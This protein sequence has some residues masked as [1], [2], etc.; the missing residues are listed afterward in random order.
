M[1][2]AF[3]AVLANGDSISISRKTKK[4]GVTQFYE[5]E[6]DASGSYDAEN[7]IQWTEFEY[8]WYCRLNDTSNLPDNLPPTTD[9]FCLSENRTQITEGIVE[10]KNF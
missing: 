9:S 2:A 8:R 6:F 10:L 1:N 3:F 4:H 7:R 5:I